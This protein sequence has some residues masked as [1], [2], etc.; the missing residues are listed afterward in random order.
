VAGLL[1][2]CDGPCPNPDAVAT[3]RSMVQGVFDSISK[4]KLI[5]NSNILLQY[6]CR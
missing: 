5:M 2:Q 4:E 3:V 6:H 1:L